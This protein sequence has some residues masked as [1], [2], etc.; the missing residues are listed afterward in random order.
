[1]DCGD[2]ITSVQSTA[3][4]AASDLVIA[5]EVCYEKVQENAKNVL[6]NLV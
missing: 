5:W 2:V 4:N 3:L 1:M 6:I